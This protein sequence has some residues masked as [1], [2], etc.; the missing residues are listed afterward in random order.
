MGECVNRIGKYLEFL[1]EAVPVAFIRLSDLMWEI[2][3]SAQAKD[4]AKEYLRRYLEV[5]P[6]SHRR[7]VWL[8]LADRCRSS[9]D[10]T[11]E[12]H[13][14]CEAALLSSFNTEELSSDAN[15]LN[16]RIRELKSDGI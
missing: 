11:E 9:Q 10:T 13:A 4:R 2:A 14:L 8:K 12:I 1:A 6:E 15:R 5:A 7:R 3:N 16:G